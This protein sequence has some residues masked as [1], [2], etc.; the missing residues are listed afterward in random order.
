MARSILFVSKK[1]EQWKRLNTWLDKLDLNERKKAR[2][3]FNKI[4][5]TVDKS[6]VD[7]RAK[8]ATHHLASQVVNGGIGHWQAKDVEVKIK[9]EDWEL[10][11]TFWGVV[12]VKDTPPNQEHHARFSSDFVATLFVLLQLV[13]VASDVE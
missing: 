12:E 1:E 6:Q 7:W 5:D 2:E 11:Q 4:S 13:D 8:L 9:K 3:Q 10:W